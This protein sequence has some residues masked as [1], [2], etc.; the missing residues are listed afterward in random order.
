MPETEKIISRFFDLADAHTAAGYE[1]EGGYQAVR[2]ALLMQPA[3]VIDLVKKSNLR[4]LGGAGFP[5]GMKWGFVPKDVPKPKYLVVNADESEPGTFKDKYIMVHA[6]HLMIEGSIIA[7]YAIGSHKAYVYIR[8]EYDHPYERVQA[9]VDEA[10]Q[11]K[12]LGKGIFG[13]GYDLDMVVH[14]GAGAYICG[15]ETGLLSSL[16]G[17]KGEPKL[18]P[19]FPAVEGLFRSPTIV[20]NVETLA[21]V[22]FIFNRGPEWFAQAGTERTGGFRLFCVSGHVERPGVYELPIGVTL[23]DLIFTYAGGIPAGRKLKAVIPGGISAP[24]LK[25]DEIDVKMDFDALKAAGT[26]AGSGGVIVMDETVSI[27]EALRVAMRFFHHESCGQCSPCR[28]GTGWVDRILTRIALGG[29]H[30]KDYAN[31]LDIA[32]Y[33]SGTT[34]CAFGDAAAMPLTSYITKFRPE[35]DAYLKERAK[36]GSFGARS[37]ASL[38]QKQVRPGTGLERPA[39]VH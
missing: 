8:G 35:F 18:K 15:E 2:K 27:V 33:I 36:S 39:S 19:P 7:A 12:Y 25:A 3:A 37:L 38:G 34:I 5:T 11:K 1:R 9:A 20:N 30:D 6:P 21:Y 31:L 24:I 26:M 29:G 16:E 32:N 14:R 10:Y 13:T 23:R 28:E 4:G 17:K 22:P